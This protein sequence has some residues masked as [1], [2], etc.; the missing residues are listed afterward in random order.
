MGLGYRKELDGVRAIAALMVMFFHFFQIPEIH[1]TYTSLSKLAGFGQTG[2]SLFFVLSGFLITRIL[3]NT[4]NTPGFFYNFYFRRSLRIFPLYFLFLVMY[5]YLLPLIYKQPFT[6]AGQ[7]VY[8]WGYLQDFAMTFNWKH[9]GPGHFWSLAIEEHFYL[10]WPL[11]VYFLNNKRIAIASIIIIAVAFL[12][13]LVL[14]NHHYEVYYFTFSR[15]DELAIGALLALLE[16]KNKLVSKN[17]GKFLLLFTMIIIPTLVIWVYF[18]GSG[19]PVLQ[20]FKFLMIAFSYFSIIGFIICIK[21][22]SY[23]KKV[24]QIKPFLFSGK[25]SYGLYVFHPVCFGIV[26]H[27]L[28][29][30]STVLNFMLAFAFTYLI[31]TISY[32]LFENN[33]LRLKK[34]F[35][36]KKEN[37]LQVE[38][39]ISD[40]TLIPQPV[41]VQKQ[42]D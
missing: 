3:L 13:R 37:P 12:V 34:F 40:N 23:I 16:V 10:F 1:D 5:Y 30:S 38:S 20:V 29:T 6:P 17:A 32:Y 36:Y 19:N 33:F 39:Q 18:T 22:T 14:V 26:Y 21:E 7:Q 28:K 9:E 42:P 8:D 25:I 41:P 11:L 15:M 35:E 2:V 4:K 24:L 27:F 31:A